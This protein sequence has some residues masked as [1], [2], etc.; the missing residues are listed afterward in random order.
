LRELVTVLLL[1]FS[2]PSFA[3]IP[4]NPTTTLAAEAGN[5]T[6]AASSFNTQ[7]NGNLG[8]ANISK[9][10]IRDL[11]YNGANTKIYVHLMPWFGPSNHMNVGYDSADAA[12]VKRQVDDMVSRGIDGAIVDWYGP[13][14][15]HHDT[16]T[17]HLMHE[18]EAHPGFEFAITEDVGAIKSA[19]N[20]QQK[21]IDDLKFVN[22]TYAPSPAY[23]RRGG[24]P[25]IFFFGIETITG[26][27]WDVV[28]ASVPGNP[29]FIF[30]NSGAFTK[31]QT[32]GGFAWLASQTTITAGYMSLDYLDN[33]YSTALN[34]PTQLTFG[35][36]FKGFD[37]TLAA[38]GSKRKIKQFCGETWLAAMDR[39]GKFYSTTNQLENLQIVTWND[40]EEGSEIETG[41]DNCFSISA[42]LH[43]SALSW[44]ITGNESTIAHYQVFISLD[45][46]NLMPLAQV[47]AGNHS[48]NLASFDLPAAYTLHVKAVGKPTIV[49]HISNAV[50]FPAFISLDVAPDTMALKA[51]QSGSFTVTVTP[52]AAGFTQPVSFSC[53]GLPA[54]STCSFSPA[55]VTPGASAAGT[56]MTIST[57]G[58]AAATRPG[59]AP[60]YA[61]WLSG[62][63]VLGAV[64]MGS[65]NSRRR[66][67][68]ALA[69]LGL[70]LLGMQ[71]GCGSTGRQ[72]SANSPQLSATGTFSVMITGTA[73]S[74]QRSTAATVVVQ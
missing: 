31:P 46:K 43:D 14:S 16:A 47:A 32:D 50:D 8:A 27:D 51:G 53:S 4:I 48:L 17:M 59:Q 52:D 56:T 66:R 30:R 63:G 22:S 9:L 62:I 35:S 44:K 18:A 19:S 68:S 37:D 58:A 2:V 28:R 34:H 1:V 10:P 73:G 67:Y 61:F 12:Q 55:T 69:L 25:V 41:I 36:G 20:P 64:F 45:G 65:G 6:S 42:S 54:N 40:Y 26:V 3:V 7:S 15:T 71:L 29:L 60:F 72:N 11:L 39:A 23:M 21:L 49:N 74:L 33:F 5:N 38:W 13:F 57:A 24:R 70:T